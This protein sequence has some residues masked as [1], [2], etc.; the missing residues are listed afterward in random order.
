MLADLVKFEEFC[1]E[2]K[3]HDVTNV[4]QND[5]KISK[6]YSKGKVKIDV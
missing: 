3:L 2:R 5:G 4:A 6:F 1:V